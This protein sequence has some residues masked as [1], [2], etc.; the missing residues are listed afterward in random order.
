MENIKMPSKME[1]MQKMRILINMEKMEN[2]LG[3]QQL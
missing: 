2:P 3:Q 1:F